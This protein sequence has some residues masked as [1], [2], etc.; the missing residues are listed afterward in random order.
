MS[1]FFIAFEETEKGRKGSERI[2]EVVK[3]KTPHRTSAAA[4]ALRE[5]TKSFFFLQDIS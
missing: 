1:S 5:T 2:R 4:G 3:C